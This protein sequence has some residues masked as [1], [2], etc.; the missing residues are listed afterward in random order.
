MLLFFRSLHHGAIFNLLTELHSHVVNVV[1]GS[2]ELVDVFES[3]GS[4]P[5]VGAHDV[6]RVDL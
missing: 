3:L 1:H 6:Q 2:Q 4:D 5:E